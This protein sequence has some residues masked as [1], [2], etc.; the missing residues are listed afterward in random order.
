[1]RRFNET[2]AIW[3]SAKFSTMACFWSFNVLALLPAAWPASLQITQFISSGYLQ[4]IALP[5]LAVSADIS[6]RRT[7]ARAQQDHVAIMA[8][9][10]MLKAIQVEQH[11]ILRLLH[12]KAQ[13]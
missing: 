2:V 10:A 6:F 11:E 5:L 8:E 9:V 12:N 7:E 3:L 13:S 4:L 1:M